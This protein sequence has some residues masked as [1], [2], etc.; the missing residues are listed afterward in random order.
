VH[1]FYHIIDDSNNIC[2]MSTVLVTKT[3]LP[4][5]VLAIKTSYYCVAQWGSGQHTWNSNSG[6]W[7]RFPG[8]TTIPLGSNPGQVFTHIASPVS[9]LQETGV[10]KGNFRRLRGYGD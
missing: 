10:Q 7:V 8:R 6:T 5:N 2:Q 4:K 9:Q 3:T 1:V